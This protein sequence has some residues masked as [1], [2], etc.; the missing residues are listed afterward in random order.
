MEVIYNSLKRVTR[1]ISYRK[2]N[3]IKPLFVL[4]YQM[5]SHNENVFLEFMLIKNNLLQSL[6][7]PIIEM[8]DGF[9]NDNYLNIDSLMNYSKIFI[10]NTIGSFVQEEYLQLIEINGFFEYDEQLFLFMDLTKLKINANDIFM[11]TDT[12]F[13][14]TPHEIINEKKVYDK[15][16]NIFV[17]NFF[18]NNPDF[19]VLTDMKENEMEI[20]TIGY[21]LKPIEKTQFCFTFGKERQELYSELGECY[22]FHSYDNIIQQLKEFENIN[23]LFI[24]YKKSE[25]TK[26]GVIRFALFMKKCKFVNQNKD[27]IEN[28]NNMVGWS[29]HFDSLHIS[30][31]NDICFIVKDY[32]QQLS[33]SFHYIFTK[34]S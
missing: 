28:S 32:A 25:N 24:T 14:T 23:D 26:Y 7:F 19:L 4:P 2:S 33:L 22:Y 29:D 12:I 5:V 18:L 13:M 8:N 9:Y 10:L 21:C 6:D 20:P 3:T 17:V 34:Y 15:Y 11:H 16:V 31:F 1:D 30:K 27:N